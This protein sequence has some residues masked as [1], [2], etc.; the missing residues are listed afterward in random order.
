MSNIR[1]ASLA[2]YVPR[3]DDDAF[4]GLRGLA[5]IVTEIMAWLEQRHQDGADHAAGPKTMLTRAA[6][7]NLPRLSRTRRPAAAFCETPLPRSGGR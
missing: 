6:L 3:E 7:N 4:S 5:D 1:I 2:G